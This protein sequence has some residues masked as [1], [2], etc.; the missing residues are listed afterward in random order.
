MLPPSQ[1][2][3][4]SVARQLF[5]EATEQIGDLFASSKFDGIL[6]MAFKRIAV[7]G[8]PPVFQNMVEQSLLPAAVFGFWLNR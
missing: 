8:I 3:G 7:N 1:V 2:G 5:G 4:I 6:G